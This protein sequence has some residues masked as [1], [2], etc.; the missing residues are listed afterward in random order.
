MPAFENNETGCCTLPNG[1]VMIVPSILGSIA[2]I[3]SLIS[4]FTCVFVK[5]TEQETYFEQT[6]DLGLWSWGLIT[7]STYGED[8]CYRYGDKDPIDVTLESAR[9]FGMIA[10][11]YGGITLILSFLSTCM[12]Y[13][14]LVL[15]VIGASYFATCFCEGL[16]LLILSADVC[17]TDIGDPPLEWGPCELSSG[18]VMVIVALMLWFVSGCMACIAMRR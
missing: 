16:K 11:I 3:I 14:K 2:A 13:S 18:A 1:A 17:T 12:P 15:G 10:V 6:F 4:E 7:D 5:R 8:E 9:I